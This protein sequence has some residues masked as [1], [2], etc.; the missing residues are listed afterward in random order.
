VVESVD[1]ADQTTPSVLVRTVPAS[2][3]ATK[4]PLSHRT[5]QSQR[6]VPDEREDQLVPLALLLQVL[7][8]ALVLL[9]LLILVQLAL[10]LQDYQM[11]F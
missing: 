4:R 5:R 2:P 7:Q 6:E 8:L 11:H 1:R 9:S 10:K 3:T